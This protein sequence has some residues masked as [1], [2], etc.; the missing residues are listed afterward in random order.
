MTVATKTASARIRVAR[1]LLGFT[2]RLHVVAFRFFQAA[3]EAAVRAADADKARAVE[4]YLAA[5]ASLEA[6]DLALHD[7][8]RACRMVRLGADAAVAVERERKVVI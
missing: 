8:E 4:G 1:A 5:Q 2:R 3:N 7:K 6:A